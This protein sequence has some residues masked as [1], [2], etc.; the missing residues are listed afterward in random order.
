MDKKKEILKMNDTFNEEDIPKYIKSYMFIKG[1][2][3]AK[4]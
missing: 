4:I 3:V 2:S 1:F